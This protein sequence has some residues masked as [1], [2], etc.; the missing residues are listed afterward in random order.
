MRSPPTRTKNAKRFASRAQLA[1][2]GAP[3]GEPPQQASKN[4]FGETSKKCVNQG[5]YTSVH[6]C[7]TETNNY[8]YFFVQL[9]TEKLKKARKGAGGGAVVEASL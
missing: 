8:F 5:R 7:I 2:A 1:F 4:V 3:G 9:L 6:M